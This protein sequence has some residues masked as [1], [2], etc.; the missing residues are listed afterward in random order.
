MFVS[1]A[2]R[3]LLLSLLFQSITS[4]PAS[5][6]FLPAKQYT[7]FVMYSAFMAYNAGRQAVLFM[8]LIS[9]DK[10]A[11]IRLMKELHQFGSGIPE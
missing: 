3:K 1:A 2:V 10:S 11:I 8:T 9:A 4:V 7:L 6:T 5:K